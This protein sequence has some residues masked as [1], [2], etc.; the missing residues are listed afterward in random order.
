MERD[1]EATCKSMLDEYRRRAVFNVKEMAVVL[2]GEDVVTTRKAVWDT[3][4]RDP[5]FDDPGGELSLQEQRQLTFRRVKRLA[6]YDF[7]PE[8][9][10]LATPVKLVGF[11]LA[12]MAYD[13]SV[14]ACKTLSTEVIVLGVHAGD[15][16]DNHNCRYL[17]VL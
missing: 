16:A 14:L 8:E 15:S 12:L 3:M 7:V 17:V 2:E 10:I 5:L 6:E 1:K 4:A 13:L 9:E 11:Q